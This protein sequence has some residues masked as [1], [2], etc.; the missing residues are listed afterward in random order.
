VKGTSAAST[1]TVT[2]PQSNVTSISFQGIYET[3]RQVAGLL[4]TNTCYNGAAPPCTGT[5]I[6]LPI[7]QRSTIS[8]LPN[9]Q[10][11]RHVD[12]YNAAGVVTEGDDYDYGAGAPGALIKKILIT[13][14]SLNNITAFQQLVTV[15][16]GSGTASACNGTGTVVSQTSFNYDETAVVA[17]IAATPQH[18][19]V[20]GSRGNLT[21]VAYPV[22]TNS[23][24]RATY[25][26]TGLLQTLTDING[27]VTTYNF[28][29]AT[30]TCGNAFPTKIN[31]PLSMSRSSAW[32][33]TGGVMTTLTDENNQPTTTTYSDT[34]FWRPAEQDYPDGGQ[35]KWAYNSPTS[36]QTTQKMNSTQTVTNTILLDGF[37]R[38]SQTQLTSDP[39]GTDYTVATYDSLG[40]IGSVYN[41]TRCSPPTTNC[42]EST[43]GYTAYSY[44]ALNRVTSVRTQDGTSVTASYLNNTVTVTD[45]AAKVRKM[46]TD[47]LGRLTNVVEDPSGSNYPTAYTYDALGNLIGVVQNGSR[48]RSFAYDAMSRL[49]C[50]ANPEISNVTC[51]NPDN[52]AYTAGTIRYG[53]DSNGNLTSR[54]APAPNQTASATLTTN[55]TYDSLHRLT[56]KTYSD[57]TTASVTYAYDQSAPWGTT[58][59]NY[60]GRLTTEYTAYTSGT[61]TDNLYN[62][63]PMG[64]VIWRGQCQPLNC[65]LASQYA[66]Y[67]YDLLGNPTSL[68]G[69][70]SGVFDFTISYAYD[71]AAR[72]TSVTSSYVDAQ[73]PATL[74]TIP[75]SLGYYPSSALRAITYGNGLTDTFVFNSRLQ[76][77]RLNTNSSGTAL[78]MCPDAI[79]SGNLQDFNVGLNLNTSDNGNVTSIVGAGNQVFNRAYTYD[80]LN[81]LSTMADSATAQPCKGLS[82]TYDAWGNRTAQTMTAG[83]SCNTFND[84]SDAS[85][86]LMGAPYTYD[87]AGNMTHDAS[88]SYTYDPEGRITQ[89]DGGATASYLYNAEGQRVQK[90]VSGAWRDYVYDNSGNVLAETIAAGWNVGYVYAVGRLMAEYR[91]S[92][93]YFL[94]HDHLG[95]ARL[96][97]GYPSPSIVECDDYYPYGEAN[98]NVGTCLS[99]TDTTHKFTSDERDPETNLDQTWFR[100]NSSTLGRWM[101]PDPAGLAAV[102]PTSPQSW[103]RYAY[104]LN[105]P[106]VLIDPLGLGPCDGKEDTCVEVFGGGGDAGGVVFIPSGPLEDLGGGGGGGGGNGRSLRSKVCRLIPSGRAEGTS[107][108]LG[109]LGSVGGGGELVLNYNSGQVSAFGFGGVQA[110]WSGGASGSVYTGFVYGLNNSN[111]NYSGGFTGINAGAGV[112]L[113]G[114]SSS[115]GL[116]GRGGGIAPNGAVK[117]GGAGFGGSLIGAFSGG[118]TVT[119]YSNPVPLGKYW[120]FGPL[121]LLL[122]GARR[123]VCK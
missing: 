112:G 4:T 22:G 72:P 23:P 100:K 52:G 24:S 15:C 17:N 39:T 70:Q 30:S 71:A 110:G 10:E 48:N 47:A 13:Y 119:N 6:T 55:Y 83:T 107:G 56:G 117:V 58:L 5:A 1:T 93:T 123:L 94:H 31:E 32:N 27:A 80:S 67:T 108:G 57:G 104:V 74:A 3:Q 96:L 122:S 87:A 120:A 21:S 101:T 61:L 49:L 29:D 85:N 37:G 14:A 114:A 33:C 36:T 65:N 78:G 19:A 90:T 25:Y 73:H 53:Y 20:T 46:Q 113:F 76:P 7:T 102:D 11:S 45:Q 50:E 97:T 2:D 12:S 69:V 84:Q 63:D 109:G 82:W 106:A 111:S 60:K 35:I 121:D 116:T 89:V 38:T 42:G 68:R 77:C 103:N 8:I 118:V 79:P 98:V 88:H 43:W 51:P 115:G 91:N 16:N 92:T 28:P 105:S 18:L 99:A 75:A 59:T 41:P 81:R 26:D 64:R 44:D 86:H 34:Q 9:N 66:M 95:S 40:R 54:V 62:Y